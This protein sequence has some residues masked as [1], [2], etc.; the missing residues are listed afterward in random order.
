MKKVVLAAIAAAVSIGAVV[1]ANA[2]TYNHCKLAQGTTTD[3]VSN[4][5]LA[6]ECHAWMV[7]EGVISKGRS[8]EGKGKRWDEKY[9]DI[10]WRSLDDS[11]LVLGTKNGSDVSS[12]KFFFQLDG[13]QALRTKELSTGAMDKF[14][15]EHGYER[16]EHVKDGAPSENLRLDNYY[17][18]LVKKG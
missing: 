7:G 9:P 15:D 17:Y 5:K 10:H 1:P 8:I 11:H 18:T 3:A 6:Q 16:V 12:M 4:L 14:L 13:N 2:W